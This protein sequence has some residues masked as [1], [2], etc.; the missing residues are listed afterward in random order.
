MVAVDRSTSE[1]TP[2]IVEVQSMVPSAVG[3]EVR[4]VKLVVP[5]P[6]PSH[7]FGRH[8]YTLTLTVVQ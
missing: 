7:T 4:K 3:V 8:P 2:A 5:L 1:S 6:V